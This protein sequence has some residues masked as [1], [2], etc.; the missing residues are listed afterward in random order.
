[1]PERKRGGEEQ[2]DGGA[3]QASEAES[4]WEEEGKRKRGGLSVF[5]ITAHIGVGNG[6]G[7][8]RSGGAMV[9]SEPPL[10][11]REGAP[12]LRYCQIGFR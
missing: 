2:A 5:F 8:S 4:E 9:T 11:W 6:D 1:M 7:P 3:A 12:S 10:D